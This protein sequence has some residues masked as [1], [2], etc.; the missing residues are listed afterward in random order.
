MDGA[1]VEVRVSE[2]DTVSPGQTLAVLEAMKMEHPLR[3][4]GAGVIARIHIQPGDQVGRGQRLIEIRQPEAD[5][6]SP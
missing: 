3:A 1:I 5:T 6:T 2:G 4:T